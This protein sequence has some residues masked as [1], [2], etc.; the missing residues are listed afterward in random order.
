MCSS[1]VFWILL[2]PAPGHAATVGRADDDRIPRVH[3]FDI[4]RVPTT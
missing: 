1:P 4:K 2:R 3:D